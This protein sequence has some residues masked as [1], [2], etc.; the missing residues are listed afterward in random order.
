MQKSNI[1]IYVGASKE[2]VD[3]AR[4]GVM[5]ILKAGRDD[6]TTRLALTVLSAVT[7]VDNTTI[8]D[9]VILLGEDN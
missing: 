4:A 3:S 2:A 6:K 7:R 1:G 5:E 8:E 9:N